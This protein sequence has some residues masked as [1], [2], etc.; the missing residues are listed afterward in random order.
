MLAICDLQIY[1]VR[2][3]WIFRILKVLVEKSE[4]NNSFVYHLIE[5]QELETLGLFAALDNYLAQSNKLNEKALVEAC[6]E[7]LQF[8]RYLAQA[9]SAKALLDKQ[10]AKITDGSKPVLG[11]FFMALIKAL[12]HKKCSDGPSF[13]QIYK[14]HKKDYNPA[15]LSLSMDKLELLSEELKGAYS[16]PIDSKYPS[17]TLRL[18][19]IKLFNFNQPHY[20]RLLSKDGDEAFSYLIAVSEQK[21][22]QLDDLIARYIQET[23]SQRF[24]STIEQQKNNSLSLTLSMLSA[25]ITEHKKSPDKENCLT[26]QEERVFVLLSQLSNKA[27]ELEARGYP[28]LALNVKSAHTTF[29]KAVNNYQ[30]GNK[31]STEL[32]V[33]KQNASQVLGP[34]LADKDLNQHR[35]LK[36]IL[37]NMVAAIGLNVLYFAFLAASYQCRS[38]FWYHPNTDSKNLLVEMNNSIDELG[39][40]QIN[41]MN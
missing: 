5:G 34:L 10:L 4:L 16:S 29:S 15:E 12:Y 30:S 31:T 39:G 2:Y 25:F 28:E 18:L 7:L 19:L 27:E 17:A 32:S 40:K 11:D 26:P 23:M 1:I 38:G 20:A 21:C 41:S 37:I 3:L 22:Q 8:N 35:G 33:L 36:K 24:K 9:L 6:F 13:E 14:A